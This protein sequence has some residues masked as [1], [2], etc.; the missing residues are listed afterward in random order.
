MKP[1]CYS[2][3]I[4]CL[5]VSTRLFAGVTSETLP[6][7]IAPEATY[8]GPIVTNNSFPLLFGSLVGVEPEDLPLLVQVVIFESFYEAD[9][10]ESNDSWSLNL[11]LNE[12]SLEDGVNALRVTVLDAGE[13]VSNLEFEVTVDTEAPAITIGGPTPTNEVSP[14]LFGTLTDVSDTDL[15]LT[16]EIEIGQITYPAVINAENTEWSVELSTAAAGEPVELQEGF[17][18]INAFV[19]DASG[20]MGGAERDIFVDTQTPQVTIQSSDLTNAVQPSVSG[21]I[22]DSVPVIVEVQGFEPQAAE[23]EGSSWFSTLPPLQ[24]GIYSLLVTATDGAGNIGTAEQTLTVDTEAPNVTYNGPTDT[25]Q[26]SPLLMGMLSEVTDSDLPLQVRVMIVES[27]F[28]AVV[29]QDNSSWSLDLSEADDGEPLELDEGLNGM[30]VTVRD[31]A[32]NARELGFGVNVDTNDPIIVIGSEPFTTTTPP[33]ISGTINEQAPVFVKIGDL[34][35]QEAMVADGSWVLP[36]AEVPELPDGT[37]AV[38][39]TATDAAGNLG[40]ANQDLTINAVAPGISFS[41]P[42][43]T[44]QESPVLSGTIAGVIPSDLPILVE[45][46]IAE[47]TYEADIVGNNTMWSFDFANNSSEST[48]VLENGANPVTVTV[49]DAQENSR[50]LILTVTLDQQAPVITINPLTSSDPTPL[51][52]GTVDDPGAAVT[53]DILQSTFEAV[54]DGGSWTLQILQPLEDGTYDLL[55]R[56]TDAAGNVGLDSSQD[57]L[58]LSGTTSIPT[59]TVNALSTLDQ[60]PPLSGTIDDSEA[61]IELVV[62]GSSYQAINNGDDTWTLNDDV[63]SPLNVGIY[64][65]Q[66]TATSQAGLDGTDNTGEELQILPAPT[67]LSEA[68]NVSVTSFD[69]TWT[70]PGGGVVN[71]IFDLATEESFASFQSG[72]QALTVGT[73]QLSVTDLDY[74]STYFARVR[75]VYS[76]GDVSD[77]S[78]IIRVQT[79]IDPGTETDSLALVSIYNGT[80]GPNWTNKENWLSG[81]LRDWSGV[82]QENARVTMVDLSSNN[83]VGAIPSIDDGLELVREMNLANNQLTDIQS[84]ASLSNTTN[85]NVTGNSLQF[86]T[87]QRLASQVG[88]V[89]VDQLGLVLEEI[90]TLEEVGTTYVV[91]RQVGGSGN[92]YRWF[93]NDEL[94]AITESQIEIAISSFDQEGTYFAEVTNPDFP[95]LVLTTRQVVLKVSSLERDRLALL[96]IYDATSGAQWTN[97]ADWPDNPNIETWSGVTVSNNRVAQ[98]D[99][100]NSNLQGEI[101]AD[102]LDI[103]N[104]E[105]V[106]LSSNSITSIPDLRELVNLMAPDV[107]DNLLDFGDLEGNAE[108]PSIN[109]ADQRPF[110][111]ATETKLPRGS[112]YTINLDIGGT[113]NQYTWTFD[114]VEDARTLDEEMGRSLTITNLDYLN[115]GDYTLIVTNQ[116]VPDLELRSEPQSVLA[117]TDISLQ[118]TFEDDSGVITNLEEGE[119]L[120]F[121]VA[122]T[123]PF[124]TLGVEM[125]NSAGVTFSDV[126]LGDYLLLVRPDTLILRQHDGVTDSLRLLP[127]YFRSSFL[128]EE[129]DVLLLRSAVNEE[130]VMQQQPREVETGDIE[131]DLLVESDFGSEGGEARLMAR[132]IV[133]RAG[134]SLRRRRRA[135]GGRG[136]NDEIFDLIAYKETDDNGRVTF[137]ELPDGFYRL[138]IEYPGVPMDPNSFIEFEIGEG[139]IDENSLTLEATIVEIGISVELIEALSTGSEQL[140]E[141]T[142]YPNPVSETLTITHAPHLDGRLQLEL[143]NLRGQ[144]VLRRTMA[145]ASGRHTLNVAGLPAGIYIARFLDEKGKQTL[146]TWRIMIRH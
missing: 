86:N 142:V 77:N 28:D 31:A 3:F 120:L 24:D 36:G 44:N 61:T 21:T 1:I 13:N 9:V 40:T 134:C 23:T 58:V 114:G 105:F 130:L 78:N 66:V 91:D 33:T 124:D 47:S 15:P 94:I 107:S 129:A 88:E 83:L 75:V 96:N 34:E 104:L 30:T 118:P 97:G 71:Y 17:N 136:A 140:V 139:G 48:I 12:I 106:D 99:L 6:P 25:N 121:K 57:E 56:A 127:T 111:Q 22:D 146:S 55:A 72:Y 68:M 84:L 8:E 141:L 92:I 100:N 122:S 116:L 80:S 110:A 26:T 50:E 16:V 10:A 45:V 7:G 27:V 54:N 137:D 69:L 67:V 2:I 41:G 76:S 29:A 62:D 119:A 73:N 123:G 46:E 38:Q 113:A 93:R 133:K 109:Y 138:N 81:R 143:I 60:T 85:L 37:Y 53:I 90:V 103:A 70:D 65:V 135:T 35:P 39:V 74:N 125:V 115:M 20:N 19:T 59:V 89:S 128:W 108:I 51:I 42:A 79:T 144:L 101:P 145:G 64:D 98:L 52:S 126:V 32:Q 63:I 95:G 49:S 117:V 132:R 102:L 11:N 87:L 112:D 131:I 4:V 43:F 18:L 5:F 14:Q 82:S